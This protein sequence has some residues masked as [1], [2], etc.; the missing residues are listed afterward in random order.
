MSGYQQLD[1][2][3]NFFRFSVAIVTETIGSKDQLTSLLNHAESNHIKLLYWP[4]ISRVESITDSQLEKLGASLVD[5][6]V[7]FVIDLSHITLEKTVL[8]PNATIEPYNPS[9]SKDDLYTLAVQSGEYSRFAVDKNIPRA[10]YEELYI[11]WIK[12]SLDKELAQEVLVVHESKHIAGMVTLGKKNGRGDIGLLAVDK[13]HRGKNFGEALV[14]EAQS[15]FIDNGY[16]TGQVVT[17]G[18][19]IAACNLYKKCGYVME[20]TEYYYHIWL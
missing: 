20:K 5:K 3:T 18:R 12:K 19:N 13:N 6:K 1:W 2:D 10:K 16:D 14:R 17:Q 11:K 9:L 15:W 7:T 4:T 8:S